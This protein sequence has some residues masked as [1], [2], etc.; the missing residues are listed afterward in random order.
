MFRFAINVVFTW[1]W[2]GGVNRSAWQR[3][4]MVIGSACGRL[5]INMNSACPGGSS[6]VLRIVLAVTVFIRSATMGVGQFNAG[7]RQSVRSRQN[8]LLCSV[9]TLLDA[10][11]SGKIT[12]YYEA[13]TLCR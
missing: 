11:K 13:F 4:R 6:S 10:Y 1:M 3:E 7:R 2:V 5:E 9:T 12:G 8:E